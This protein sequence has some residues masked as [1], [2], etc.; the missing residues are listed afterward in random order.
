MNKLFTLIFGLT[1]VLAGAQCNYPTNITQ[2][3]GI[4]TFCVYNPGDE[5]NVTTAN[6]KYVLVDVVKGFNY[7]FSTGNNYSFNDYL[8]LYNATT[9]A[10]IA[11]DSGVFGTSINWTA[12]F[13]G[14]VKVLVA[15]DPCTFNNSKSITLNMVMTN[16]GNTQDSQTTMGNGNWVGHVYNWYGNAPPSPF[17]NANYV[18]YYNENSAVI[19]QN[20]GGN[21]TC[22]PV[23]SD[24]VIRTNIYTETFA[25]R[26]RMQS[27]KPA[28]CYMFTIKGDDGI[29]L[30]NDGALVFNEWKDQ[31]T[32]TY[33]NIL[34]NLGENA[35]LVFDYY[36]NGG[37][38][39]VGISSVPFDSSTNSIT[40]PS[41]VTVCNNVA[42][43]TINGSSYA[44]FGTTINPTI[45]YQW[46]VSN[47]NITFTNI[48]GATGQNYTPPATNVGANAPIIK[49]Y[50]RVISSTSNPNGCKFE[51]SS[52]AITTIGT[53]APTPTVSAGSYNDCSS[54]TANWTLA[55]GA[56]SYLI[57]I[58]TTSNFANGTFVTGYN[59]ANV[60]NVSS[61]TISGLAPSTTY[62][63]RV[64]AV[65]GT[66][67]TSASSN[68]VT[69]ST[70][71]FKPVIQPASTIVCDTFS[72]NWSA[73]STAT[74]YFIDVATTSSFA[75]GTFVSGYENKNVG[76][77]TS[78]TIS[79]VTISPLYYRVRSTGSCGLSSNSDFIKV[80]LNKSEWNGTTWSN[81]VPTLSTYAILNGNYDTAINGDLNACSLV[82]NAGFTAKV[83]SKK[84][85]NIQNSLINN[86]TIIIDNDG[87]IVQI[88]ETDANSGTYTGT[89]FQVKRITKV[90]HLDYVYWSSPIE[91][92]AVST[93]PNNNRFYWNPIANNANGSQGNF[94]AASGVM[95]K[96]RG[97]IARI[98][99][100]SP[101]TPINTPVTFQGG[102]PNNG[103]FTYPIARGSTVS[104]DDC[105]NLVGNPYPS[106]I[107]AD[108][109]LNENTAIEGSVRVWKHGILPGANGNPF[110]ENFQYTYSE[111]DYLL[112]NATGSSE[113]STFNGKI[114]SGQGF[115]V[116]MLEAGE[117]NNSTPTNTTTSGN[118][119]ITFKN[120]YR[121]TKTGGNLDNSQFYKS[122]SNQSPVEK[123]RI[124]L[125]LI[126]SNNQITSTV[127]GY[128]EGATLAKDRLYDALI[129]VD[130]F[131]IYSLIG[132]QKQAIQGRPLPFD[133]NDLVPI[134]AFIQTAG[135][136]TI[137]ISAVDGLFSDASQNIYLEDKLTNVIHDL[138]QA[139]YSFSSVAG[140]F[141]ERFVLR[142]TNTVLNNPTFGNTN[143]LVI[144]S[145]SQVSLSASESIKSVMVFDMLG[146]KIHEKS[147]I[148][149]TNVVLDK[150]MPTRE[151]LLIK[152]TF[153][154]GKVNTKKILF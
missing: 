122:N 46:Q 116:R 80:D 97:Y 66:C 16:V 127:V 131:K 150:L 110:Y 69:Y 29:R 64:R 75:A 90:K 140:E 37:G 42:P 1:Y 141:N 87:S 138:K 118:A 128:I 31:G 50:R 139:P 94:I 9:S 146:R 104:T 45:F 49:Y 120:S 56:T 154:N 135:N 52:I 132:T 111:N 41:S 133:S 107:D 21:T 145:N 74:S 126:A 68:F 91:N 121:R 81:G 7:T 143:G 76:N 115:F 114:A 19:N 79:G 14:Q 100:G 130:A 73:V 25:V 30:Y 5:K 44:Y 103:V 134:G 33:T 125:D 3:G 24:G 51:S 10:L 11:S 142:Y 106:A 2:S 92:F 55:P 84:F 77:V 65:Y 8:Y 85:F 144:V 72:A 20:F 48:N 117:V 39:D 93:L 153:E 95:E 96:G 40:A 151:A 43:G 109:F 82:V 83:S 32:N 123:S 129:E 70:V 86:G 15:D 61:V 22:F 78:F 105:W 88:N 18:G 47:N 101:A 6:T 26:Y 23:Y 38:N 108:A 36:E 71:N 152:T 113:P 124:W 98:S 89:S 112:Y 58:A 102:K 28:G 148:N 54:F 62:Y 119:T 67:R 60:G 17:T 99:N 136:Y 53:I 12:T 59:N 63:Y 137:A 147:N 149:A 27:T 4:E 34:V 13:S 35:N 57:D